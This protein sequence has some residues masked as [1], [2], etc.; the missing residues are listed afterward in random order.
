MSYSNLFFFSIT[1]HLKQGFKE[2]SVYL[3][4]NCLE[5][6]GKDLRELSSC[7]Q[8]EFST[9]QGGEYILSYESD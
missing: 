2:V 9:T 7:L 6:R 3:S 8:E 1:F 4:L 5:S